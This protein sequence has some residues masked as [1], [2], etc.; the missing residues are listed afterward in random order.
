MLQRLIKWLYPGM[1]VKRYVLIVVIGILAFSYGVSTLVWFKVLN[2]DQREYFS[3]VKDQDGG[4]LQPGLIRPPA[5]LI[6]YW[7]DDALKLILTLCGAVLIW[8]GIKKL[9][10]SIVSAFLPDR[11]E[12]LV[13][14]IFKQRYLAQGFNIVALGG[15]HGLATLLRGIKKHTGNITAVVTVAD[16]GGSSGRLRDQFDFVP[17]GDLRNCLIALAES[18]PQMKELFEY[19]FSSEGS[20]LHGHSF[21]NLFLLAMR[22]V[23]GDM[24]SALVESG[25]ILSIMGEVLPSTTQGTILQAVY[26]NGEMLEGESHI[27]ERRGKI[28]SIRLKDKVHGFRRAVEK[29]ENAH[30]VILGPG[31]LY[32]SLIP[33][34]LVPEIRNAVIR[35]RGVK[36][37]VCNL[38]TQDGETWEFKASDHL[39]AIEELLGQGVID[40]V[41][42]PRSVGDQFRKREVKAVDIDYQELKGHN[43]RLVTSDIADP[44]SPG[45][46]HSDMLAAEVMKIVARESSVVRQRHE[47]TES[48]VEN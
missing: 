38:V 37:Y 22:N 15:G 18:E 11:E 47:V 10:R 14:V 27:G 16:D 20:E 32:T 30:A 48:A 43:V 29:I 33:N 3:F 12:T 39:K 2:V 21:G 1:K 7:G 23:T 26:E 28:T 8:Q 31:S 17:P 6:E 42:L 40:Y 13:D 46:H 25:K 4:V 34:L 5:Q 24:E 44:D 45:R 35:S 19:R 41:L 36:I 9:N